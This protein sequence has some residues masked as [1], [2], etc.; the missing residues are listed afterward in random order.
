MSFDL[1]NVFVE[2][3]ILRVGFHGLQRKGRQERSDL[4]ESTIETGGRKIP[5]GAN[6]SSWPELARSG[7]S[8]VLAVV[9]DH[10]GGGS[11]ELL[12]DG[13]SGGVV[14]AEVGRISTGWPLW[15]IL[16]EEVDLGSS[17]VDTASEGDSLLGL[18]DGRSLE[19]G[20]EGGLGWRRSWNGEVG[21]R[22]VG[23]SLG[24]LG[25][26]L[27][28]EDRGVS[29]SGWYSRDGGDCNWSWCWGELGL[30]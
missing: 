3:G 13:A 29:R 14:R 12:G 24:D 22:D 23:R 9:S 25:D 5:T 8:L 15:L 7:R 19:G 27:D 28:W 30:D 1:L 26:D 17:L 16:V 11:T 2:E 4:L 10:E 20:P 18:L 6:H 21:S